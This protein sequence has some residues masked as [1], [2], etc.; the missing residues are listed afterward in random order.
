M[1]KI[2]AK[3]MKEIESQLMS[4]MPAYL[5]VRRF[6][7]VQISIHTNVDNIIKSNIILGWG[8]LRTPAPMQVPKT[9]P[10]M[11]NATANLASDTISL[12]PL[13][14]RHFMV[15]GSISK[16]MPNN[17]LMIKEAV[18]EQMTYQVA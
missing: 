17:L 8:I 7:I 5:R 2:M 6:L 14:A 4:G 16:L 1:I 10:R 11:D 9:K 18:N 15:S 13:R 12:P 3:I